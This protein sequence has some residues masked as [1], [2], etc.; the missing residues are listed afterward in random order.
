MDIPKWPFNNTEITNAKIPFVFRFNYGI[1][2]EMFPISFLNPK[3]I[4]RTKLKTALLDLEIL[5]EGSCFQGWI[6]PYL[7]EKT[8]THDLSFLFKLVMMHLAQM[9][10]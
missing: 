4:E 10:F 3:F 1:L 6:S 2:R 8:L 7:D 9:S 5:P